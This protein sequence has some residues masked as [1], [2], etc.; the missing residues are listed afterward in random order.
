[1]TRENWQ[2]KISMG[3]PIYNGDRF[4]R[5]ALD[6]LL[7]QTFGDLELIISDNASTDATEEICREYARAD[8]RVRY[9]RQERN[10]GANANYNEVV[11][12]SRAPLFRWVADDDV[13]RP[14]FLERTYELLR[15]DPD[16]V[17]AHSLTAYIDEEGRP[18]ERDGDGY[19]T[20]HGE[21][22][23]P[24]DRPISQR[25][26]RSPLPHVRLRDV[27]LNTRWCF[28]I[29]GL[30]RRD[31][32]LKTPLQQRFYGTDKVLLAELALL[33]TWREAEEPLFERRFHERAS[34]HLS[35]WQKAKWADPNAKRTILPPVT[36]M[37]RGYREAIARQDLPL[38]EKARCYE[39]IG[40]LAVQPDKF[41]KLL[42]PGPHNYFGIGNRPS[43]VARL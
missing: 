14:G 1:M 42:L 37:V 24:P 35:V 6:S 5:P 41:R 7:G 33:G 39:A 36:R 19:R 29:F 3:L 15:D 11:R 4:L 26:L 21:H 17:L 27:L 9:V 32:L 43:A 8:D 12:L 40:V 20:P 22:V 23:D 16:A 10:I 38:Y 34:N 28:E 25:R 30:L 2:P 13:V 18:L 31:A